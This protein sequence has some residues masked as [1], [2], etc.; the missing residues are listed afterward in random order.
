M[1]AFGITPPKTWKQCIHLVI[2]DSDNHKIIANLFVQLL[3]NVYLGTLAVPSTTARSL[4]LAHGRRQIVEVAENFPKEC[5]YVL[6]TLGG[7]YRND[8]LA[9]EQQLSAE[10]R[11][12]FTGNIVRR[13]CRNCTR[14]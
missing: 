12:R 8:A 10:E 9:R 1:N 14:G 7:V 3:G 5:R 11:L 13:R 4:C 2:K 6:E